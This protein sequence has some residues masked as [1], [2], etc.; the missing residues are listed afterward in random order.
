MLLGRT[1]M[2]G[3]QMA[4]TDLVK[5]RKPSDDPMRR[6]MSDE[7]QREVLGSRVPKDAELQTCFIW[8]WM[9]LCGVE[10]GSVMP[11]FEVSASPCAGPPGRLPSTPPNLSSREH[12]R[13][14][15]RT[16]TGLCDFQIE[17]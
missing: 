5:G 17:E 13:S 8:P 11:D 14:C 12:R 2:S 4:W 9:S 7:M 15:H 16:C 6:E 1:A 10:T 3:A